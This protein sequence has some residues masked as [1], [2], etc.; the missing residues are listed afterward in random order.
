MKSLGVRRL[1][2]EPLPSGDESPSIAEVY[3]LP[4]TAWLN[5]ATA[6]LW[7]EEEEAEKGDEATEA[8]MEVELPEEKPEPQ[9]AEAMEVEAAPLNDGKGPLPAAK[10]T[11]KPSSTTGPAL[12]IATTS[13]RPMKAN[14][15]S[16]PWKRQR[17]QPAE[18]IE[19]PKYPYYYEGGELKAAPDSTEWDAR[20]EVV[21]DS[22]Y[23]GDAMLEALTLARRNGQQEGIHLMIPAG[24]VER[25]SVR[26][27]GGSSERYL[28]ATPAGLKVFVI[29]HG[30]ARCQLFTGKEGYDPSISGETDWS[31][32]PTVKTGRTQSYV[33]PASRMEPSR[34][35]GLA[36]P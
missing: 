10:N 21:F 22:V 32:S 30:N 34:C 19:M 13:G 28:H 26:P 27:E 33:D 2:E 36:T 25:L 7:E 11:D 1:C 29:T 35:S 9:P 23:L 24:S 5:P 17:T 3:D 8:P 12:D 15:A 4:E 18:E 6:A 16:F 14:V 20:R 31:P